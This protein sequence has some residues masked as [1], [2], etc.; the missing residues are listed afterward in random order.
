MWQQGPSLRASWCK[1]RGLSSLECG[2][3]W[4]L[5]SYRLQGVWLDHRKQ[6]GLWAFLE[7][8]R[9][10]VTFSA[11][12]DSGC[13]RL[14]P[15]TPGVAGC[16]LTTLFSILGCPSAV[17]GCLGMSLFV[18]C[19]IFFFW[20]LACLSVLLAWA[21]CQMSFPSVSAWLSNS[22]QLSLALPGL[23]C[24]VCTPELGSRL[25]SSGWSLFLRAQGL[26]A[27]SRMS[28]ELPEG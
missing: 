16:L 28:Q 18:I 21:V 20:S 26:V 8:C 27:L 5:A 2:Y 19:V 4:S 15:T 10:L 24:L 17:F 11:N 12:A 23:L 22:F 13:G 6:P 3:S 1:E 7:Q 14:Y 25:S 9:P